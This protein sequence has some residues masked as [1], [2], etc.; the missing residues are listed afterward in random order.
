MKKRANFTGNPVVECGNC[1][2]TGIVVV[3]SR[4]AVVCEVCSGTGWEPWEPEDEV[5]ETHSMYAEPQESPKLNKIG[6][7]AP[8]VKFDE[9]KPRMDL[10]PPE[11]LFA[12]AKIL[13]YGANKYS[14]RNWEKGMDWGRV[15]AAAQRHMNAWWEGERYDIESGYSHLWHALVNVLMLVAFEERGDGTDDRSPYSRRD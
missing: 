11:A 3:G 14:A 10:I 9:D 4:E 1:A 7:D 6:P 2:G 13:G 12:A 15:Y 8:G 5:K